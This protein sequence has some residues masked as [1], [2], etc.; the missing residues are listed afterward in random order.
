MAGDE[1]GRVMLKKLQIRKKF[2]TRTNSYYDR[3]Y[4]KENHKNSKTG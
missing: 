4:K 2:D 1:N 3:I